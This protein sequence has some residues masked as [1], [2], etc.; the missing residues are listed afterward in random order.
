MKTWRTVPNLTMLESTYP[1]VNYCL[2]D[3]DGTLIDSENVHMSGLKKAIKACGGP[4]YSIEDLMK[5]FI[6]MTDSDC[7]NKLSNKLSKDITINRFLEI[8]GQE[9]ISELKELHANK[10][11]LTRAVENLLKE[12]QESENWSMALV[13]ASEKSFMEAA[14]DIMGRDFFKFTLC[15]T[16]T[17]RSKPFPDPYLEAMKR[18]EI[19]A[20]DCIIF[21]DSET[22]LE[23]ATQSGAF[24][25]KVEWFEH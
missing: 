1:N 14:L 3:L 21:E 25:N 19:N 6:G 10:G 5:E 23:A 24:V 8:K 16:D 7:F 13:T 20:K 9:C 18:F 11:L 17:P 4:D 15:A 2:F 12:I 22:G